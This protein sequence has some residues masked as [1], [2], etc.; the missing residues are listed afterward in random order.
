MEYFRG[1]V[2][3]CGRRYSTEYL[4]QPSLLGQGAFGFVRGCRRRSR[5]DLEQHQLA[6]KVIHKS[7]LYPWQLVEEGILAEGE[8]LGRL[9]H[10][11]I[12]RVEGVFQNEAYFQVIM[13]KC[14]GIT[15]FDL[16][17]LN[18]NLEE[19]TAQEVFKQVLDAVNYLHNKNIVHNDIKDENVIVN[20]DL[21]VTLIDFGS[22]CS[23]LGEKTIIY[24]GSETYTSPEVLAGKRFC[25][26]KQ[27]VWSL[28]VLLFV[29]VYGGN[30]FE[31]VV[32][33]EE[34]HLKFPLTIYVRRVCRKL[35][36]E[37][38]T[39]DLDKR[40]TLQQILEHEW[41]K[42]G[43]GDRKKGEDRLKFG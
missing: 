16:I 36:S 27:E 20:K 9:S 10:D 1:A 34:C 8:I 42:R 12:I 39:K 40:L 43:M 17:E 28:G 32:R 3:N 21:K 22:A 5:P 25:R 6:T 18:E 29:M 11:N 14:P 2:S 24:C 41:L 23:N 19:H 30:P 26:T 37:V 4:T 15:L 7:L 31:D 35:L 38:L 33:A 13:T